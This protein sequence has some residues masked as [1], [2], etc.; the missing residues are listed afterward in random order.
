MD[1]H[2]AWGFFK[3]VLQDI[4]NKY[5]PMTTRVPA[6]KRNT[7]MSPQWRIQKF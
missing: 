1:I 7:Y 5:V 2:E 6:E 4:I 3:M